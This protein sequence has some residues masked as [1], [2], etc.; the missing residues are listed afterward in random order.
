MT[1]RREM[2]A[3]KMTL[4]SRTSL[5]MIPKATRRRKIQRLTRRMLTTTTLTKRR[6]ST[7]MRSLMALTKTSLRAPGLSLSM[8]KVQPI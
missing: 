6:R 7:R 8:V 2:I 5:A 1:T 3:R 4:P